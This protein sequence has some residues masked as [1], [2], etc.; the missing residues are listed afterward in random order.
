M[1]PCGVKRHSGDQLQPRPRD[2]HAAFSCFTLAWL[3][4]SSPPSSV[5]DAP[6]GRHSGP[7]LA[8]R[9]CALVVPD[10]LLG[11]A[12]SS[13]HVGVGAV[14]VGA[15]LEGGTFGVNVLTSSQDRCNASV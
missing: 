8:W 12:S 11:A 14:T 7:R 5:M 3:T 4:P 1:Y 10:S 13:V 6:H 15:D 2:L 9:P